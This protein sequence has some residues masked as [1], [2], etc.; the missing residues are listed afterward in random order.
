MLLSFRS[1]GVDQDSVSEYLTLF[2]GLGAAHQRF[3]TNPTRRKRIPT[4]SG[5]ERGRDRGQVRLMLR[6]DPT[7]NSAGIRRRNAVPVELVGLIRVRARD[8]VP[9]VQ[10]RMAA[11]LKSDWG[12]SRRLREPAL[13]VSQSHSSRPKTTR[14]KIPSL[15]EL[16][17]S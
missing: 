10:P 4:V 16:V 9:T 12:R 14:W 11:T 15:R 6:P 17:L 13:V 1:R 5:G 2:G 7:T 8:I 3:P